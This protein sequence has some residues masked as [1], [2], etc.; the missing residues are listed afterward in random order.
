MCLIPALD[1]LRARIII[2]AWIISNYFGIWLAT[3][4]SIFYLLKIANS[5]ILFFFTYNGKLKIFFLF[6]L[7]CLALLTH[8][9]NINKTIQVNDYEGNITQKT[10]QRD[11]LH[12]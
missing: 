12:L 3:I 9:V 10:K 5:P 11:T 7:S 1:N 2:I 4:L 6:T 8:G